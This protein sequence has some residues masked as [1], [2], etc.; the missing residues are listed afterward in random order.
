MMHDSEYQI[1]EADGHWQSATEHKRTCAL[2]QSAPDGW[3]APHGQEVRVV[4]EDG[5]FANVYDQLFEDLE[6]GHA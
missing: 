6:P 4:G 3:L 1:Q 5:C 2:C